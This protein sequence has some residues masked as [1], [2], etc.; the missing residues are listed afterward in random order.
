MNLD[1]N[2]HL[3]AT[4]TATGSRSGP[5]KLSDAVGSIPLE[6]RHHVAV[7]VSCN[8]DVTVAQY[9]HNDSQSDTLN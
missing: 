2:D 7:G 8:R 9:F 6:I 5:E 4:L 1:Q 3:T